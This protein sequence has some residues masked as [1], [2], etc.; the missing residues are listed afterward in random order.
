M[1]AT[2]QALDCIALLL[3]LVSANLLLATPA[4]HQIAEQGH[5][6][7]HMLGRASGALQL[8]LLPLSLALSIDV[9]LALVTAFRWRAVR[10]SGR[11]RVLDRCVAVWYAVPL[12]SPARSS[13]K[14]QTMED[15]QQSV[16]ARITQALT[17]LRVVLPGAQA[18]FGFRSARF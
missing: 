1:P 18:L 2:F 8:A 13:R 10:R 9:S 16:E 5:A 17:E 14:E 3:I 4:Y 7:S 6:T 12:F 15:K 11:W